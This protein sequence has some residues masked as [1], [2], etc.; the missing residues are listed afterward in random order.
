MNEKYDVYTKTSK[1]F[2]IAAV[3]LTLLGGL[4]LS[5]FAFHPTAVLK[6]QQAPQT[7][8][9]E[10][11]PKETEYG[12]P[13]PLKVPP[14]ELKVGPLL[15]EG[16]FL[17]I[18][19]DIDRIDPE[20]IKDDIGKALGIDVRKFLDIRDDRSAVVINLPSRILDSTLSKLKKEGVNEMYCLG[21][22]DYF[23][24]VMPG[25]INLLPT[26]FVIPAANLSE[27][28]QK[29]LDTIF[30][31]IEE[32]GVSS[33]VVFFPIRFIR[34]GF[35][36]AIPGV[37]GNKSDKSPKSANAAQRQ[38]IR[39][40]FG[41]MKPFPR[42][43][44][45]G[46]NYALSHYP[47]RVIFSRANEHYMK[48]LAFAF[49][50]VGNPLF[51]Q[52][53][54][55]TKYDGAMTGSDPF[56]DDDNP[57]PSLK[58]RISNEL[59]DGLLFT[60][61][62]I[63]PAK[64]SLQWVVY[65]Q[66]GKKSFETYTEFFNLIGDWSFRN[67]PNQ[68]TMIF[69]KRKIYDGFLA[70]FM[71]QPAPEDPTNILSLKLDKEYVE[72]N[73]SKIEPFL[74][75]AAEEIAIGR[76]R[77]VD[78]NNLKAISL[79]F[80]NYHDSYRSLPCS[81]TST[82]TGKPLQSWRVALLPF[83]EEN[84]LYEKIRRDEPWDSEYNKQFHDKMPKFYA[85]PYLTEDEIQKGLTNYV[86]IVGNLKSFQPAGGGMGMS[87]SSMGGS[88]SGSGMVMDVSGGMSGITPFGAIFPG[89][90]ASIDFSQI[91]DGTSNTILL[92]ERS[93]PVCWMDPTGDVPIGIAA[94]GINVDPEGLGSKA[95]YHEQA[96]INVAFM[97][98]RVQFIPKTISAE[99]WLALLTRNG[100]ESND[101][102][103][104]LVEMA[105]VKGTVTLDGTPVDQAMVC[106]TPK[107]G[108]SFKV[109]TDAEGSFKFKT[110]YLGDYQVGIQK[111][112]N[113]GVMLM[114]SKYANPKTSG[115]QFIIKSGRNNVDFALT[116][117]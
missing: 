42:S 35:F 31:E 37:D 17:T 74:K 108:V 91:T 32:I 70:F 15:T 71:P 106:F 14:A 19:F 24:M 86:V 44:I 46:G 63:D 65:T 49:S 79:A 78:L 75:L 84:E 100:G 61:V 98:A 64:P 13:M 36:I 113:N 112:D 90:N 25:E 95:V 111:I 43:E 92:A 87:A 109:F 58:A 39:D 82:E 54:L 114:P 66:D 105:D 20:Q 72:T 40:I 73:Q 21:N 12:V 59:S 56:A 50:E 29:N 3:G 34:N 76:Q 88:I 101:T 85:S 89:P 6:A 104:T 67:A 26:A 99:L 4:G 48:S 62:G 94:K 2:R 5:L 30:A 77:N 23:P 1:K 52:N 83:L 41:Q 93:K 57:R 80:H 22:T 115:L 10:S 47:I 116:G 38:A 18:C 97:D 110:P 107:D 55:E 28:Q 16:S 102:G 33:E 96:G 8:R 81:S 103:H 45:V 117:K 7:Q 68:F 69:G 9:E 60:C 51:P 53:D 11:L 27:T